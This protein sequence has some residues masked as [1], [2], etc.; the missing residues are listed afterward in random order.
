MRYIIVEQSVLSNP[1][2]DLANVARWL[3]EIDERGYPVREI[4][5]GGSGAPLSAAPIDK[6]RGVWCDSTCLFVGPDWKDMSAVEFER[7]WY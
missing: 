7:M 1:G 4:A 2:P 3:L 5:I 6:D